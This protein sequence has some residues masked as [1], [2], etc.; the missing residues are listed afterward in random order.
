MEYI[1]TLNAATEKKL[2]EIPTTAS[3]AVGA[4]GMTAVTRQAIAAI[5]HTRVRAATAPMP[6]FIQ[7]N[8]SEPPATPPSAPNS[9]GSQANQAARTKVSRLTSTRCSV[10][11]FVHNEYGIMLKAFASAN[12]QRRGSRNRS[13][14]NAC[15]GADSP[16]A[17][18][19]RH[20]G[21][22]RNPAM[23]VAMNAARQP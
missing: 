7:R 5:R 21:I 16:A 2:R 9:G 4:Q 17:P 15:A 20:S 22:H 8:E 1:L 12:P 14:E 6:A 19:E 10:V 23:A 11:Q 13:D 3:A 18:T